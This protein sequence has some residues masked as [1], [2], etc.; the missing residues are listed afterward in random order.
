MGAVMNRKEG[1]SDRQDKKRDSEQV[2][3]KRPDFF[4]GS[5]VIQKDHQEKRYESKSQEQKPDHGR[6]EGEESPKGKTFKNVELKIGTGEEEKSNAHHIHPK[7]EDK[8]EEKEC[9]HDPEAGA[10][11]KRVEDQG[12]WGKFREQSLGKA[13][14]HIRE[15]MQIYLKGH[16]AVDMVEQKVDRQSVEPEKP[17]IDPRSHPRTEEGFDERSEFHEGGGL[18]INQPTDRQAGQLEIGKKAGWVIPIQP[19]SFPRWLCRCL[20]SPEAL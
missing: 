16:Q 15:V 14:D 11:I 10:V 19:K 4:G 6:K 2:S 1:A 17:H 5:C 7:D 8:G 3:F 9:A 18:A 12:I 13:A 20:R